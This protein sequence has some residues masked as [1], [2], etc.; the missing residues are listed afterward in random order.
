MLPAP[1]DES[2]GADASRDEAPE[3][4]E[5]TGPRM[6]GY[7]RVPRAVWRRRIWRSLEMH[8]T[9]DGAALEQSR[10]RWIGE[11]AP[12]WFARTL[13]SVGDERPARR[14]FA[15][16]VLRE[17]RLASY[18]SQPRCVAL[19]EEA[20][21]YWLWQVACR[22]P[23]LAATLGRRLATRE[24]PAVMAEALLDAALGFIDAR[25]RFSAAQVPLPLSLHALSLQDGR[26][27]YSGL[28]PDPGATF[29]QHADHGHAAFEDALRQKWPDVTVD[30]R[31]VLA[32]LQSKA[33]GRLPEP[34]LE[35]IR[36][37]VGHSSIETS[38]N[39][40]SG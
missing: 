24:S 3:P 33:A 20:D 11:L 28:L 30:G 8:V 21:R 17:R 23:T 22:V 10:G 13:L 34:I 1:A 16:E 36:A 31:A 2:N 27:V 38:T 5:F 4:V 32:D 35:I 26:V 39:E 12:G 6:P 15:E 7:A 14:A 37:V 29:I 40:V 19:T 18:L 9:P 25:H